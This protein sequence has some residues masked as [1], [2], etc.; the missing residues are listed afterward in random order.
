MV[1][2]PGYCQYSGSHRWNR[3]SWEPASVAPLTASVAA[4][5]ASVAAVT[6]RT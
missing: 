1:E 4:V 3:V 2:N 5:T 6:A